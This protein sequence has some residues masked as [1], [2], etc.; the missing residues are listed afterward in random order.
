[1]GVATKRNSLSDPQVLT[2]QTSSVSN[3]DFS[4]STS[5]L[6]VWRGLLTTLSGN[7]IPVLRVASFLPSS[8]DEFVALVNGF[9]AQLERNKFD[10]AIID[11]SGNGYVLLKIEQ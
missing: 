9:V 4:L 7:N 6:T 3:M 1:M 10:A 11:M 5:D 8:A 2:V